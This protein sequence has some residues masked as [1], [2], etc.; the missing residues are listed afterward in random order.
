MARGKRK[1][2]RGKL[3]WAKKSANHGRKGAHGK[4]KKFKSLAQTRKQR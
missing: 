3:K 4:R 2:K 1:L